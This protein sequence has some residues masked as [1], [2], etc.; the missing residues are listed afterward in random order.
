APRR[1]LAGR[2][3]RS[4]ARDRPLPPAAASSGAG[5]PQHLQR[6]ALRPVLRARVPPIDP[7]ARNRARIL[8]A[9]FD[10]RYFGA[11]ETSC[12]LIVPSG[13]DT[14]ASLATFLATASS[15]APGG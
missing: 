5:S 2:L 9:V 8:D 15:S 7:S 6:R 13:S 3:P 14:F 4:G 11:L 10:R 12:A 1:S